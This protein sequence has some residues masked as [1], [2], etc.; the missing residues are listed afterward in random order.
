MNLKN[1]ILFLS[2]G[3]LIV[4]VFYFFILKRS[5]NEPINNDNDIADFEDCINA[6]YAIMESY[7]ARC[8]TAD[9]KTFTENIGNEISLVDLIRINSLRP[10]QTVKSPLTISGQARGYW[11]F[12]ASFPAKLLD[13][14][15]NTIAQ[16]I[17]Q[18][19]G[20]WMTEDFVPFLAT[21]EFNTPQTPT[22]TLILQKDNPSGLPEHNNQLIVPIKFK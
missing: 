11:F 2:I 20:E 17:A 12:E 5:T 18:A 8:K 7:P 15:N 6:G 4:A 19:Q 14:N 22:G 1:I 16:G 21:I 13:A 10:N 9:G 3:A